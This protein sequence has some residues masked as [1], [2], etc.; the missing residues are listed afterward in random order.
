MGW[1][2]RGGL[3]AAGSKI[4]CY[5]YLYRIK[6][7]TETLCWEAA[8]EQQ[9]YLTAMTDSPRT[10]CLRQASAMQHNVVPKGWHHRE[11]RPAIIAVRI[12]LD[13]GIVL[14]LLEL[15]T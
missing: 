12:I 1:R 14:F 15:H 6:A 7:P 8:P 5:M 11:T 13:R 9:K 2:S 10:A 4:S 3:C